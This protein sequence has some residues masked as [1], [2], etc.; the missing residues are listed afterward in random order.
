MKKIIAPVLLIANILTCFCQ[1]NNTIYKAYASDRSEEINFSSLKKMEKPNLPDY[2]GSYRFGSSED[3][4]QLEI[5]YSNDRLFARTK[6]NS[7]ENDTWVLKYDREFVK[8]KKGILYL[9]SASY[10]LYICSDDSNLFLKKGT[11]GLASF[12]NETENGKVYHYIQFNEGNSIKK[13]IGKH[14]ET[15]FV[16]L[17]ANDLQSYSKDDLKIMR[18]ETFARNGHVFK[19]GGAMEKYFLKK[20]WYRSMR[21]TRSP[22]L[23]AIEKHNVNLIL[24]LE[25]H[26]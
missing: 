5:I 3:E 18:N 22:K 26:Q 2:Q 8:Y 7:W 10:Q 15:S 6:Y 9:G 4:S 1:T 17:S 24:K 25:R 20:A 16:K 14:P 21:K 23:N 12:H 13:P 19:K 11:K